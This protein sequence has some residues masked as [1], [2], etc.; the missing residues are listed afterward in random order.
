MT[1]QRQ[2]G[3]SFKRLL[4]GFI[5][6]TLAL[7]I[8]WVSYFLF[9]LDLNNY[10]QEMEDQLASLLSSPV[11]IGTLHYNF[12]ETNL[13][14]HVANLEIGN[15]NSLLQVNAPD[16]MINLQ[17]RGLFERDFRFS[18]ISV[19][20]PQ[21]WVRPWIERQSAIG[22][23]PQE[24]VYEELESDLLEII[25][26]DHLEI[27]AGSVGIKP[28]PDLPGQTIDLGKINGEL[29]VQSLTHTVRSAR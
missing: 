27:I 2:T 13:A 12:H 10:R 19:T 11:H 17:W 1:E 16:I 25:S 8:A 28:P 6:T 3:T 23:Q 14:L 7:M 26:I 18:K 20:Q 24:T 15:E 21:V 4:F 9:T 22:D 29:S 5:L